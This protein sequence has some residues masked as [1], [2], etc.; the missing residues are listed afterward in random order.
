M[1]SPFSWSRK[2]PFPVLI[3]EAQRPLVQVG[4]GRK[5]TERYFD[6]VGQCSR[7]AGILDGYAISL[8]GGEPYSLW[9]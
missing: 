7:R 2:R 6:D 9:Y 8:C 1:A 5:L 4:G 3:L